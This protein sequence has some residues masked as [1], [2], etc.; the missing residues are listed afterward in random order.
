MIV[1]V[2]GITQ[3]DQYKLLEQQQVDM[4]GLNFY[5]P[6]KRFVTLPWSK[7][8]QQ[9]STQRIGVFVNPEMEF[10]LD[11]IDQYNLDLVQLHGNETVDFCKEVDSWIP[12]IKAFGI[13]DTFSFATL[14]PYQNFVK[15]FLLDTKSAFYG[16][17]G[18]KFSWHK[19]A[20]YNYD[21]PFLLSGGI[22]LEDIDDI[23]KLEHKA[24]AGI[25]VNSGFEISPGVKDLDK[26]NKMLKII[27]NE[28]S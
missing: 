14:A 25:D 8:N 12:V 9:T 4:V 11:M 6:S 17:S 7:P 22:R 19:L 1:K 5:P 16:G 10:L 23:L 13:D 24:L 2:C 27:H 20:E 18:L 28:E 21:K 26:I 15:Y 3:E